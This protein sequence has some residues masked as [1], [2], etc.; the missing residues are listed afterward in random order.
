MKRNFPL[1]M[2][3]KALSRWVYPSWCVLCQKSLFLTEKHICRSCYC[4]LNE[5]QP[6]ICKHCGIEI[7]PFKKHSSSCWKCKK[8]RFPID[9]VITLFRY[10]ESFKKLL[11]KIKFERKF[12]L[13]EIFERKIKRAFH[14]FSMPNEQT[15]LQKIIPVPLDAKRFRKRKFNQS[16]VVGKILSKIL[17]NPMRSVLKRRQSRSPQSW[18][19]RKE[20]ICNLDHLFFSRPG[21]PLK[22]HTAILVDDVIT[23]GTTIKKCSEVLKEAGCEKIVVFSLARTL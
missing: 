3:L 6:P 13:I 17:H 8:E 23:T 4:L 14:H 12:W 21:N 5:I 7:P 19:T 9:K 10:N 15:Q 20:R 16:A 18:L 22:N 1:L 11:H 2:T